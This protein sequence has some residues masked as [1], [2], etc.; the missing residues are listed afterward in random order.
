MKT[1]PQIL[2]CGFAAGV[3]IS[4]GSPARAADPA[5]NPETPPAGEAVAPT[6]MTVRFELFVKDTHASAGFYQR[7]LGFTCDADS[8]P[9]IRARSGS[10]RIGIC[11][12]STLPSDHHFSTTALQGPKGVG[13]EIVLEVENLDAYHERVVKAGY[14]IREEI[15]M[16]PWGLRDFRLVDPDGYYL[17]ITEKRVVAP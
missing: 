5:P 12:Q 9:Y 6:G 1:N 3:L 7:V 16:R 13:T 8:G 14:A 2:L 15:A 17:R 10:V 4:L 11:D